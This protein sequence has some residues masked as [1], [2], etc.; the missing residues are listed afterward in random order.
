MPDNII[1]VLDGGAELHAL[2][3][4]ISSRMNAIGTST[5]SKDM[6][7]YL[8]LNQIYVRIMPSIQFVDEQKRN[9]IVDGWLL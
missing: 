1:L 8:A 4:A 2:A 9:S 3:S 6:M 5:S 7:E